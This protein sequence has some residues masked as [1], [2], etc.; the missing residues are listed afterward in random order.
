[1]HSSFKTWFCFL[2]VFQLYHQAFQEIISMSV[3]NR[4][5]VFSPLWKIFLTV[6]NSAQGNCIAVYPHCHSLKS[7]RMASYW[8]MCYIS[9]HFFS[10]DWHDMYLTTLWHVPDNPNYF[11]PL[12]AVSIFLKHFGST[13]IWWKPRTHTLEKCTYKHTMN[14]LQNP[15]EFTNL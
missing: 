10:E 4:S 2:F 7:T 11:S 8:T 1:M 14:F 9:L 6:V 13:R 12:P 5:M 15:R 3:I